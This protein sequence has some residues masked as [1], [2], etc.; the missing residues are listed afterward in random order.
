MLG[1]EAEH[2][3]SLQRHA[4]GFRLDKGRRGGK[5]TSWLLEREAELKHI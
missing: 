1:A 4:H 5:P 3:G 2:D